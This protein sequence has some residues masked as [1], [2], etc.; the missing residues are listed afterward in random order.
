MD[1]ATILYRFGLVLLLLLMNGFFV[2]VEFAVVAARRSRIDQLVEEGN[3][4][5]R[6]VRRWM[7]NPDRLIAAAQLG[8]TVASL[9]LG[10]IGESAVAAVIEPLLH[11]YVG[12]DAI[13]G[14]ARSLPFLLSLVV[15]TSFHVVL[16]EQAPKSAAIRYPERILLPSARPMQLF[17]VV[18]RP[19]VVVL[20]RVSQRVLGLVGIEQTSGHHA[21]LTIDELRHIVSESQQGG[22]LD[23]G[24][25]EM[26][27]NIFDFGETVARQVMTPRTEIVAVSSETPLDDLLG[28]V[29]ETGYTKF[30]V[31]DGDLDHVVGIIHV[32]DLIAALQKPEQERQSLAGDLMREALNVP[33]TI[34]VEELL[35]TFRVHR[36][37]LAILLDEFG[38]TSGLVTLEDL[39]EEIVGDVQDQFEEQ[40]PQISELPGGAY[41]VSGLVPIEDFN[42]EFHTRLDDPDYDTIAGYLLGQLGRL[43]RVGDEVTMPGGTLRVEA[44]DGRRID[45]IVFAPGPASADGDGGTASV[46]ADHGDA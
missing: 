15:V 6:I 28:L 10:Y 20:D 2:A 3:G 8:I 7:D 21:V 43:A 27:H 25:R 40:E 46:R 36:T 35:Q 14:V 41:L 42:A 44:L 38:G 45:R 11:R 18:F 9:A 29:V 17:T 22:V 5:A 34:G 39:L 31:Y 32:K 16:G 26:L 24:E 19:F 30:P 4:A 33:E 23:A 1:T 12:E 13:G 37:H